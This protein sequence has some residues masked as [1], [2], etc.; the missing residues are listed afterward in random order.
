VARTRQLDRDVD[1]LAVAGADG[2]VFERGRSGL[3]GRGVALRIPWPGGDPSA[4][5]R[6]AAEALAAIETDDQVG[7]PGC[8]PVAFGALPFVPGAPSELLVPEV[9]VGRADDGTRWLTTIGA[10]DAPASDAPPDTVVTALTTRT[11][12]TDQDRHADP[13]R[14]GDGGAVAEPA[15]SADRPGA[16]ARSGHAGPG[17][18]SGRDDRSAAGPAGIWAG[19]AA[20]PQRFTVEATMPPE[21]WCA[22]VERATKVLAGDPAT[23]SKV[24]LAREIVVGTDRPLDRSAV[25]RRLRAAYPGCHLLSVDGLVGASP[26]LLVS[27]V[28]DTVRSHPLAGTAPRGGDPATDQRLAASL[29]ASTKDREE[30]QITIDMVHDTL[31]GWCSYLDY[32][33]EPS[34]LAVANVQHLATLVEGRLSRP[35][36]SVLELVAALHPTPAVAGWPRDPAVAWIVANEGFDR[37]RYAG[38][39]GWADAAGNGTWAVAVRCAEVDGTTA[40]VIAGNGIVAHS[41]PLAELAETQAKLQ[42]LLSSIVRP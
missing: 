10:A 7:Q 31:V 21:D 39:V 12:T 22:L 23:L 30:H 16:A 5:A 3:A 28:G 15:D 26:E 29:L 14:T 13:G 32:E 36:P 25:L 27:R 20:S 1:L 4:A 33:A 2:V 6:S 18:A 8:G 19:S 9:V 41:D 40:R 42:A 35:A 38:T 37:G 34:I 11:A 17:E 24:V